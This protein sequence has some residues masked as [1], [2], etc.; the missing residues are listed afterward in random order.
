MF[1]RNTKVLFYD[2]NKNYIKTLD[3]YS[4]KEKVYV[5]CFP[6]NLSNPKLQ[7]IVFKPSY[8]NKGFR[9]MEHFGFSVNIMGIFVL[10]FALLLIYML[11]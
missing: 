2:S 9:F 1:Q 8:F 7:Y 11:T 10:I 4:D 6:F 3:N 5:D